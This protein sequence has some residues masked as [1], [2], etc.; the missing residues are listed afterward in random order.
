MILIFFNV[1]LISCAKVKRRST[2]KIQ[3]QITLTENSSI[4]RRVRKVVKNDDYFCHV[5]LSLCMELGS[6]G[7]DFHEI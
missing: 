6:H 3:I 5:C 2:P 7:T 1:P 4:F